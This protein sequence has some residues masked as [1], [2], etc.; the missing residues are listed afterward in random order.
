M[1][2]EL[3][4]FSQRRPDGNGGWIDNLHGVRRVLYHLS[5]ILD[6]QTVFLAEGEK[7]AD[8]LWSL[9]LPATTCP[10]GAGKW[11]Q[12]YNHYLASKRVV[13][14]PDNDNPGE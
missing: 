4:G 14:L 8:R 7:D 10:G 3:R 9:G 11:L 13:T 12:E 2:Y 1:R 6:K 5:E